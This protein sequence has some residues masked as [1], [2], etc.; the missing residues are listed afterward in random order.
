MTPDAN[1]T[2]PD[3]LNVARTLAA[4]RRRLGQAK[5]LHRVLLVCVVG[6]LVLGPVLRLDVIAYVAMLA[7][8]LWVLLATKSARLGRLARTAW[9]AARVGRL[10]DAEAGA[11]ETLA[12]FCLLRPVTLAALQALARVAH[13]RREFDAA[14]RLAGFVLGRREKLLVGDRVDVRLLLVDALLSAGNLEAAGKAAAPLRMAKLTLR[15]ALTLLSLRLRIDA[16]AGQFKSMT[17]GM[18]ATVELAELLPPAESA[19]AQGLLMLAAERTGKPEWAAWLRRR[20]QLLTDAEELG[21][22]EPLLAHPF[23]AETPS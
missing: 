1:V 8:V 18:A 12:S 20:V 3:G 7:A 21:R 11:R 14:A 13:G 15:D 4:A 5:L 6:G 19:R 23:A 22:R 9:A 17:Q 16:A 10:D 2:A